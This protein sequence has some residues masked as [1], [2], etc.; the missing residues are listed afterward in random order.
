MKGLVLAGGKGTRLRPLTYALAKQLIP[1]ANRP[2]IHYVMDN[3]REAEIKQ[4]GLIVAPETR[5][6]VEENLAANPWDF[7]LAFLPQTEP[8]GLAHAVTVARDFL[9]DDAFVMYLGDNLMGSGIHG[10]VKSFSRSGAAASVLLK[11]VDDP[12]EFGVA[13]VD[14]HGAVR[15]LVEKPKTQVSDLAIVGVYCFSPAIHEAIAR[16]RPSWRGELEITDAI[17][18]LLENGHQVTAD[19]LNGWWLDCGKKGDLLEG[20]RLVL[21]ERLK[22]DIKGTVDETSQVAGR[23]AAGAGSRIAGSSVTGPVSIGDGAE[24]TGSSVGPYT[25]VGPRSRIIESVIEGS[26][27]LEGALIEGVGRLEDSVVGRN[28]VVRG[29]GSTSGVLRLMIGDEAEVLA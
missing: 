20:N 18:N 3:L 6:Q 10:M 29:D 19:V 21:E 12:S 11:R 26:L 14:D 16:T 28:C 7:D 5:E 15:R 1:V 8:L 23:V 2:I 24:I 9:G 25:S 4:V 17:Q 22:R 27:V 13:V